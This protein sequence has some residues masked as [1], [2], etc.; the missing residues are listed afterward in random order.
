MSPLF[1]CCFYFCLNTFLDVFPIPRMSEISNLAKSDD[2]EV[3]AESTDGNEQESTDT[4]TEQN[5]GKQ[6]LSKEERR[7][8]REMARVKMETIAPV[9]WDVD[10]IFKGLEKR[11][12]TILFRLFPV[13]ACIVMQQ[14]CEM[15][16]V[17]VINSP[18]IISTNRSLFAA[19]DVTAAVLRVLARHD[20]IHR[21]NTLRRY[22]AA[23]AQ[24]V[25]L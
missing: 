11:E 13:I 8:K 15:T 12:C 21:E 3:A 17:N 14:R 25:H 2:E 6:R 16:T 19:R 5:G 18:I 1:C 4:G 24:C 20:I 22:K 23:L 10:K 9:N 7:I